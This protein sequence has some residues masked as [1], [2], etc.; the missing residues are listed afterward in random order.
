MVVPHGKLRFAMTAR[1][2]KPELIDEAEHY[3]GE[4]KIEDNDIYRGDLDLPF[5]TT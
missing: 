3:R 5:P 4:F 2:V 1:Y